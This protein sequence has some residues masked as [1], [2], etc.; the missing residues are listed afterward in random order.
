MKKL[1]ILILVMVG[2]LTIK[3]RPLASESS[4]SNSP[5]Y[6]WPTDASRYLTSAFCEYRGRRF[7][8]GLDIKTR[9][10]TGYNVFAIRPGYV[11]RISVSPYGYG[12][13]LYL[14][15]DTGE[16]AVYAHLSN[17]SEKIRSF[18]EAEQQRLGKYR[19]NTFLK[20]GVIP[21]SKGE[22][23]AF[24]GQTG[25]GA[26]HLHFEIRD[27]ANRPINPLSKGYQLPDPVKPIVRRVSFSPL[28][29]TSEVNGDF[30]PLILRPKW[31]KPGEYVLDEPISMWGNVGLGISCYDK[32]SNSANRFG[33]YSLKLFVDGVLRFRYSYDQ[34]SFKNNK[35]VDLERDYRLSRRGLGRYY[36]LY[37]DKHN[38]RSNYSPNKPWAGVLRSASLEARPSLE[39]KSSTDVRYKSSGFETGSLFPGIHEF[40]I[41]VSD[42]FG[43]LSTVR[44]QLQFGAAF[45][46]EPLISEVENGVL[47]LSD[48]LTYD[49]TKIEKLSAFLLYK[50][51]WRSI[52]LK[53]GDSSDDLFEKGGDSAI[54]EMATVSTPF[55]LK[56]PA[57]NPLMLKFVAFD[58]FETRSYPYFYF[59]IQP[60]QTSSPPELSI[61]YDYYDDYLRLEIE[62]RNLLPEVPKVT[63]YPGRRDSVAVDIYQIDLKKYIGRIEYSKLHGEHH[64][65]RVSTKNLNDEPFSIWEN[66][67]VKKINPPHSNQLISEDGR[68]WVNFWRGSLYRP[69][70]GRISAD[71]VTYASDSK[72][73]GRVYDAEPQDVPLNAGARVYF[74]YSENETQPEKLGVYYQTRR[75]WVFIDNKHDATSRAVSAKVFSLEKFALIR[76][77]VP[78]EI[79]RIRPRYKARLRNNRPFISVNVRD[80]LSGIASERDIVIRLNGRKLIAEYDPERNRIFYQVKEPLPQ[81]RHELTVWAQDRSKNDAF[82]PSV[83]WIE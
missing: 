73:V 19:I 8:G 64:L 80:R 47:M 28:D 50:K 42:F 21:V 68:L 20:P 53:F 2:F 49:V 56:K 17:F 48:F 32:D 33:V 59:D 24:T 70:Y 71:S 5:S 10:K 69:L 27:G 52:P 46:F 66:F 58:Q 18:V 81:G 12:K 75:R 1:T 43:N 77:D 67:S 34:F 82:K 3:G 63:L 37:K 23:I 30:K 36:K 72:I 16:I 83:F 78:P 51:R 9:G 6:L 54:S 57:S 55:L 76:D 26:P 14:K 79:R 45:D 11:W 7:H 61:N 44:G 41:E 38:I 15:L 13:A 65:L 25:I 29:A 40:R 22:I 74:R 62:S 4:S 35:M 31:V 60:N 39:A